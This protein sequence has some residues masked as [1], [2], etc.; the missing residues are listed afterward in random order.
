MIH[1]VLFVGLVLVIGA[2]EQSSNKTI[3][4]EVDAEAQPGGDSTVSYKPFPSFMLP[5][6]NLPVAQRPNF[7]AGKALAHQPWIK[8]PTITTARDGLGPIYNARSCLG[9]HVNGGKGVV[10]ADGDSPLFAAFVRLSLPGLD[11]INGAVPEPVYGNQIQAQ[12]VALFHQ[13]H[14]QMP[15]NALSR[16]IETPPEAY[17]Y[18]DW[19]DK[20]FDYPDGNALSLRYPSIRLENLGYG[21]LH[22]DALVTVRNAP[23]I[24][25]MGLLELIDQQ[26]IDAGADADDSNGDGISGRVNQVWDFEHKKTVPGRFGWKANRANLRIVTAAA[27]AGDIGISNPIFPGQ[28]CTDKQRLCQQTANG[29]DDEGVEL[30][31]HLLALVVDF[32]RNLAVPKRRNKNSDAVK[33]GRQLFYQSGCHACHTPS[34]VTQTIDG[35]SGGSQLAHL[36]HLP[37]LQGQ[38]IWPYTDLLLHDMGEGLADGRPDYLASAS[39]W[40]TPPLWGAGLNSRVN[41]NSFFL[42]DGRA[43]SIEEAIVWHGGE[44]EKSQKQFIALPATDRQ[45]LIQFVQSL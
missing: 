31:E 14:Q 27:F 30:P 4:P 42:H 33:K 43:Q 9:C 32:T 29:N 25:G 1:R 36:S 16:R 38:T 22:S 21:D 6:A 35:S 18:I 19:Q 5:A 24:H 40:R 26:A 12:S 2:C 37:H 28:P 8:A 17:V 23:A 34:F 39:E 41:G 7:Y 11:T 15:K 3:P 13:L 20:A 45:A 44:A 10:P